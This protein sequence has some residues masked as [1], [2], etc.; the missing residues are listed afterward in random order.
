[1]EPDEAQPSDFQQF[2]S[3]ERDGV[4]MVE[5]GGP[6]AFMWFGGSTWHLGPC[7]HDFVGGEEAFCCVGVGPSRL[8]LTEKFRE[9]SQ[10]VFVRW[11]DGVWQYEFPKLLGACRCSL[12]H[13]GA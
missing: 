12:N 5:G 7:F 13:P 9:V 6:D 8:S 4:H 11:V 1:M 2:E 3:G 10:N